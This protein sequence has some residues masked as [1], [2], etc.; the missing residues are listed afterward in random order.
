MK[1]LFVFSSS[2]AVVLLIGFACK[3]STTTTP[4]ATTSTSST[5]GTTAGTTTAPS[6]TTSVN[7]TVN[8]AA[9]PSPTCSGQTGGTTFVVVAMDNNAAN[10]IQ[11]TF[12]GATTPANGAYTI[13]LG[14]SPTAGHCGFLFNNSTS[15]TSGTVTV[16]GKDAYFT[17]IHCVS[18]TITYTVTGN[19]IWP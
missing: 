5:T 14:T 17:N 8:G 7:Y 12:P 9:A 11:L 18:Q 15:A 6:N 2:L 3:K 13:T 16:V 10:S 4:P 1:K 19:L